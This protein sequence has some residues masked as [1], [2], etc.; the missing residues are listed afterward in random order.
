MFFLRYFRILRMAAISIDFAS[1]IRLI[2]NQIMLGSAVPLARRY[3]NDGCW[4]VDRLD[5]RSTAALL[6]YACETRGL[7]PD[8]CAEV[9][10]DAAGLSGRDDE[11]GQSQL[12]GLAVAGSRKQR[13][14]ATRSS[15]GA[16]GCSRNAT[17]V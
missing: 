12:E 3:A 10:H 17:R 11:R 7:D 15:L 14:N 1:C 6:A 16:D 9:I 4:E 2:N 5:R 13:R 8:G